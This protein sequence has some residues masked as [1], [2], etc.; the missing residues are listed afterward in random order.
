MLFGLLVF[1]AIVMVVFSL[2]ATYNHL[3]AAAERTTSAWNNLDTVLRQRH[4]EIPKLIDMCEPHLR[5]ARAA[6]D[7]VLEARAAVLGAR[8]TRDAEALGRAE[9]ALRVELTTLIAAAASHPELAASPAFGLLR[10]SS[11]TL[12]HEIAE[13]QD[14]YNDAVLQYNASISRIPG[15][16]VA[17]LSGFSPLRPLNVDGAG[18]G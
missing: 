4:D 8:Q 10:Q 14:L 1:V 3:V 13:R 17:T 2:A 12:D 7:G 18:T 9:R 5:S 6:F 15:N 11:A 16:I